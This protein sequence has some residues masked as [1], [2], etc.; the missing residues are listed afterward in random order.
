MFKHISS[1]QE[2][3]LCIEIEWHSGS[4]LVFCI[5]QTKNMILEE[6]NIPEKRYIITKEQLLQLCNAQ[7]VEFASYSYSGEKIGGSV[8]PM[9]DFPLYAK[10]IYNAVYDNSAYLQELKDYNNRNIAKKEHAERIA[11]NN[12][13][14]KTSVSII[15]IITILLSVG[16]IVTSIV[17]SSGTFFWIGIA[18]IVVS[19]TLLANLH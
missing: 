9:I 3:I 13:K 18:G 4:K 5:N 6:C 7:T 1:P 10:A 19:F 2:T 11:K 15:L 16:A 17:V 14:T 12:A 8:A